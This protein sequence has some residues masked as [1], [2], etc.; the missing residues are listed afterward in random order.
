MDILIPFVDSG[1][2]EWM[3]VFCKAKY[4]NIHNTRLRKIMFRPFLRRFSSHG[5]FKYWWRA[6]DKNYKSLGKVH[7]LLMQPSQFP[8]FLNKGDPRI[9]VHYHD[10]FIPNKHCPCFNSSTIEL[11]AIKEL[12]L[13]GNFILSNDDMYVNSECDDS[14][15]EKDGKPLTFIEE[16]DSYGSTNQ[17][18][19]TLMNDLR[20][21][22]EHYG[23]N[24]PFY[25]W[26]H[27]F[28]VYNAEFCKDF[29]SDEWDTV[30]KGL[31]KW[32]RHSDYSHFMFLF[33]QNINGFSVHD[34]RFPHVGYYEM[35]TFKEST[36]KDADRR[37]VVC[38]NDTTGQNIGNTR[39]YLESR[40]PNKC[41]F[42]V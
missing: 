28:Q 35:P 14:V 11:C 37:Q 29:L 9:V 15:F 3:D 24:I 4:P 23:K 27:L 31:G 39:D 12:D 32:R 5:F 22:S 38:F 2:P 16:R 19:S 36:Y 30:S 42:E 21:V 6:L 33:A 25:K 1:D 10:E 17:F 20:I 18:R 7:L 13:K 34:E 40:Y 8:S 41:S 26:H